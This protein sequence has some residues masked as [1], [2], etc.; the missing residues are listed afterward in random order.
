MGRRLNDDWWQHRLVKTIAWAGG[1]GLGAMFFGAIISYVLDVL[2]ARNP[3]IRMIVA[4]IAGVGAVAWI[5]SWGVI[6]VV[7]AIRWILVITGLAVIERDQTG[8]GD[9]G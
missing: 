9:K 8:R 1:Y 7:G 4:W 6:I 2:D 5:T 3:Q